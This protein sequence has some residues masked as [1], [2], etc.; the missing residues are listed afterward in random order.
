MEYK[1]VED[2]L[3]KYSKFGVKIEDIDM[4]KSIKISVPK[5][6]YI[7]DENSYIYIVLPVVQ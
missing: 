4:Y 6:S 1:H 2:L 5:D 3:L 7:K